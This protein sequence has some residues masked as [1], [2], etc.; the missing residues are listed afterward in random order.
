[1]LRERQTPSRAGTVGREAT[2][3][4]PASS[5][6][7]RMT[8]SRAMAMNPSQTLLRTY[9]GTGGSKA[10]AAELTGLSRPTLYS[11]LNKI[12]RI[13]GVPLDAP[14]SRISLHVALMIIVG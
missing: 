3:K 2:T 1:M 6:G 4:A 14:E 12:E 10:R 13:L 9:L 8:A 5:Q 7:A 11:R